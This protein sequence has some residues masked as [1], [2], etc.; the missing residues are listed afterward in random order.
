MLKH[1][2]SGRFNAGTFRDGNTA[3]LPSKFTVKQVSTAKNLPDAWDTAADVYFQQREFLIH[4][5][6]Y[7]P[8]DLRYYLLYER[9]TLN[10]GVIIFTQTINLL[11]FCK[12]IPSPI[13]IHFIGPPASVSCPG[14]I[15]SP[16][17]IDRLIRHIYKK[18]RG[19]I[20]AV[21]TPPGHYVGKAI[22]MTYLPTITM[23]HNFKSWDEYY[24]ALRS[25]YRRRV[26]KIILTFE[27]IRVSQS[28]CSEFTREM[29]DL[30]L[31]VLNRTKTKLETLSF[32]FFKH[33][34]P[35]FI[36]T[37]FTHNEKILAWNI[38]L[39]DKDVFYFFFGGHDDTLNGKYNA[40]LNSLIH[41]LRRSFD[42]GAAYIDL[43]QTA[44][45]AKAR[46]GGEPVEK[47]MFVYHKSR[48]LRHLFYMARNLLSYKRHIPAANV[49]KRNTHK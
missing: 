27:G 36:L 11:T 40:Y 31:A 28:S 21:N 7:N 4:S 14:T 2:L 47:G 43:G 24:T 12:N 48:L 10:A 34:P 16:A 29:H 23:R 15:G 20:L 8:C 38:T 1:I 42:L 35:D 25:D 22:P 32:D 49:F 9:D 18:E 3:H 26:N 19:V 5:E 44:E 17:G 41:M 37:A 6:Q 13:K 33:L 45:I 39:K 46:M 30:Y